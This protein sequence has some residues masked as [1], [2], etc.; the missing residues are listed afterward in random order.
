MTEINWTTVLVAFI[1]GLPALI[2]SLRTHNAVNGQMT[3]MKELIATS[4]RAE[5][6][7]EA[8]EEALRK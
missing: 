4:S 2:V 5:G 3:K 8:K 7:L 1:A 6:R